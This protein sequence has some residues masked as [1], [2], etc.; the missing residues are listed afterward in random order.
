MHVAGYSNAAGIETLSVFPSIGGDTMWVTVTKHN[1]VPYEGYAIVVSGAP[2]NLTASAISYHSIYLSWQ[3]NS[4]YET[5]YE[6]WRKDS[7]P[8]PNP[9]PIIFPSGS[10]IKITKI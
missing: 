2:T 4:D 5:G 9:P 7:F 8:N 3:D 6:I 10:I 1:Y